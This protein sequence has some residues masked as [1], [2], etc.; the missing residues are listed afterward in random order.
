M[1]LLLLQILLVTTELRILWN[2]AVIYS[3]YDAFYFLNTRNILINAVAGSLN[4]IQDMV[5]NIYLGG[6]MREEITWL[7]NMLGTLSQ[8]CFNV[9]PMYCCLTSSIAA[10]CTSNKMLPLLIT[11]NRNFSGVWV[12]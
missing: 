8:T 12:V 6:I 3:S 9:L 7:Q 11:G 5:V 4:A 10:M 1:L 2:L